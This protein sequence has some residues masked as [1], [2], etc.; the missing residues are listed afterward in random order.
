MLS[1]G[2][3]IVAAYFRMSVWCNG[4]NNIYELLE[5]DLIRGK[6]NLVIF[7]L[8]KMQNIVTL[9]H[10]SAEFVLINVPHIM[11]YHRSAGHL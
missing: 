11:Y 9:T 5:L 3:S 4:D 10:V 8:Y 7:I 2:L 1:D 6:Y